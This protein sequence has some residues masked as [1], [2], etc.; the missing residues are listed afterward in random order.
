MGAWSIGGKRLLA[1][2]WIALA[3][4]APLGAQPATA[5]GSPSPP[6]AVQPPA[7]AALLPVEALA[8]LPGLSAPVLSPDGQR[9]AARITAGGLSRIAV[10]DLRDVDTAPHFLSQAG[11]ELLW[12]RWAGP[13]RLLLG[14]GTRAGYEGYSIPVTRIVAV[15]TVGWTARALDTGRGIIGDDVIFVDPSGAYALVSSQPT[16]DQSP[17][18]A[19]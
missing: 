10:W 5:P 12:L 11:Y 15:E 1:A 14:V 7:T 2:A 16:W 3:S 4:A 17:A 18:V 19:P 9:I 6:A 8:E 13:S